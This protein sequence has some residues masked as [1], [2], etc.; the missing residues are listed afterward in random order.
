MGQ[1]KMSEGA[2]TRTYRS[3]KVTTNYKAPTPGLEHIVF[4]YGEIMKPGSFKTM[5]ESMAEHMA[6]TLKYGGPEASKAIKRAENPIYKEA[7]ELTG[8]AATRKGLMMFD[9]KF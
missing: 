1:Q 5:I 2:K 8:D 3:T 7:D 9:R 4:K 6:A